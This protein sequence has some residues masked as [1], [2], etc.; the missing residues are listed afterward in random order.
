MVTPGHG[1][2]SL[3][4]TGKDDGIDSVTGVL[5]SSSQEEVGDGLAKGSRLRLLDGGAPGFSRGSNRVS[6]LGPA[7]LSWGWDPPVPPD[8]QLGVVR[9]RGH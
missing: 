3:F 8:P 2:G 7:S 4:R 1:P 6:T 9:S 5:P